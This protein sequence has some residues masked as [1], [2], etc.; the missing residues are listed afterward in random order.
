[1]ENT[2]TGTVVERSNGTSRSLTDLQNGQNRHFSR[3]AKAVR[4]LFTK[5]FS[6]NK[7]KVDWQDRMIAPT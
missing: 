3:D 6:S 5:Y 1:M 2:D 4:A 7:G